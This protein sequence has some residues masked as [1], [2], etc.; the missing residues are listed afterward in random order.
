M[1]VKSE[2]KVAQLCLTLHNPMDFSPPGSSVHGSCQT[3]VLEWVASAFSGC[4]PLSTCK[5]S[6]CKD[7]FSLP[8]HVPTKFARRIN[9]YNLYNGPQL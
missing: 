5:F 9:F 3:R 7:I 6:S 8:S 2:S 4:E 1:K